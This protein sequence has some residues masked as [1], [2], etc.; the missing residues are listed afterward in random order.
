MNNFLSRILL[1]QAIFVITACRSQK[2]I[3]YFQ[4]S[5]SDD[6]PVSRFEWK[7]FPSKD[8]TKLVVY[9]PVIQPNDILKIY[10]TSINK[11]ASSYFNPLLSADI[12]LDDPQASG[13]LVD[14]YGKIDLPVLGSVKVAGMTV[15]QIRD[16]LK[17]KLTKYLENPSVRVIFDNFKITVL[18]EVQ[19]PGVYSVRNER[20]T[21]PEALGLAGDMTIYGNRKNVLLIREENKKRNFIR[22]DLTN[23]DFFD[24]P[25]YFLNPND[26]IYVEPTKGKTAIS[27]NFYRIAPIVIS[28]LT[29]I[30]LLLVRFNNN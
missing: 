4:E 29:L 10:I 1:V 2:D 16:T 21:L 7:N 19:K 11:E 28:T 5:Q 14:S 12:R 23:R 22:I 18:G 24:S 25:H 13:Y 9:E 20:L 26:I 6:K 8:T 17:S 3:T 30:S 27:D 15:P